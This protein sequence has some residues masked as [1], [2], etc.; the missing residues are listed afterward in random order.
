MATSVLVVVLYPQ[1]FVFH[2]VTHSGHDA[3]SCVAESDND[4][5]NLLPGG[6]IPRPDTF[7]SHV[8]KGMLTSTWQNELESTK[9]NAN[10]QTD[11]TCTDCYYF[12]SAGSMT[13]A[14]LL[15]SRDRPVQH[16]CNCSIFAAGIK[17]GRFA[18][19]SGFCQK[20]P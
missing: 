5:T 13:N 18:R 7:A 15:A 1:I 14:S 20:S 6:D 8:G 19:E 16:Y 12:K 2:F 11:M 10:K 9:Q 17:L 3:V 4:F